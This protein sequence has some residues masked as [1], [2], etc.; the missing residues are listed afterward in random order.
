[1]T[2]QNA[3]AAK[4]EQVA[5]P[6]TLPPAEMLRTLFEATA[7]ATGDDFFRA[8]VRQLA[9]AL[10][11]RQA[12]VSEFVEGTKRARMLAACFDGRFVDNKEFLVTGTPCERVYRGHVHVIPSGLQKLYPN[13]SFAGMAVE[14]YL[15]VPLVSRSGEILGHVVALD[16]KPLSDEPH[17]F[18]GLR[19]FA[20]RATAELE[21]RRAEKELAAVQMRLA[22]AERMAVVGR[23]AAGIAHEIN[24]PL[25]VVASNADIAVRSLE[26]FARLLAASGLDN[27]VLDRHFQETVQTVA[28][29]AAVSQSASHKIGQVVSSLKRFTG[30]DD[31]A[32]VD[33]DLRDGLETALLLIAPYLKEGVSVVR[34]FRDV[35]RIPARPAALNQVF[36]ILLENA[37]EAIDG[38]GSITVSAAVRDASVCVTVTDTGRGISIEQLGTLFDIGFSV[39]R[40]RVGMRLGLANAMDIVRSHG[41]DITVKSQLGKGTEF[42]VLLPVN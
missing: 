29:C 4:G 40:S 1:M 2:T 24:T 35:P 31:A 15:G 11:V 16:D 21:R 9:E 38:E 7:M 20:A 22:A 37:I 8:L 18:S 39:K 27:P 33:Y 32:F 34:D 30:L 5:R 14:S 13:E 19:T 17:D 25:G 42:S 36:L 6:Q 23:L 12:F 41:G 26:H 3:L 28:R 10:Q